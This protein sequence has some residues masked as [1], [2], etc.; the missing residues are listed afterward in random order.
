MVVKTEWKSVNDISPHPLIERIYGEEDYSLL[1]EQ[2]LKSGIVVR[3]K[4]TPD[5]QI[6]CGKKR[7]QAAKSLYEKGYQQ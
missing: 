1:A 7:W 4:V 5:G 2:I 6:I 3:L